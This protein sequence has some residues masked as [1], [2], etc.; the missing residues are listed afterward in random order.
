MGT[1]VALFSHPASICKERTKRFLRSISN[2]E[3]LDIY[4]KQFHT[5]VLHDSL[6]NERRTLE[7]F[8]KN[9]KVEKVYRKFINSSSLSGS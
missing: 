6:S 2:S 7:I 8:Y 4:V 3:S 5:K 9:F 1:I